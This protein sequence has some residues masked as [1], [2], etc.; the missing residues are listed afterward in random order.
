MN[1]GEGAMNGFFLLNLC[2]AC[3]SSA[4]G[5]LGH[6][7]TRPAARYYGQMTHKVHRLP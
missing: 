7:A 1:V 2:G 3:V 4:I 5:E 6:P